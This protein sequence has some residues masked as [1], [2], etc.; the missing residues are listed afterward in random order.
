MRSN[1]MAAILHLSDLHFGKNLDDAGE[2]GKASIKGL[3]KSKRLEMQAHDPI[4]VTVMPSEIK[5]AARSLGVASDSFDFYVITGDVA[6]NGSSDERFDFAHKFL[7]D[8]LPLSNKYST[9]LG[10]PP[11]K[12]LCVPGNH[13][14]LSQETSE[15]YLRAFK[16]LPEPPPYVSYLQASNGQPFVF[17]GIDSNF[18]GEGNIGV[19]RISLP[20][21]G[22]LADEFSKIDLNADEENARVRV[23]VLHHH[24]ADLNQFRRSR[25]IR[26]VIFDH[27][28]VLENGDELLD[29]C[30][31]RIDLIM[32]GHEHFPIAFRDDRSGCVIVSGGTVSEW[33]SSSIQ[34]N[35][36]HSLLFR[37]RHL[38][39][40]QF[41]WIEHRFRKSDIGHWVFDLTR[42]MD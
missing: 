14:V 37:N 23:L 25:S 30:R 28:T 1:Q 20:T 33:Q 19:G 16:M 42:Q 24:P 18:Y 17:Y 36:F 39:V 38:E 10:L 26:S 2:P 6:T 31:G 29:L 15:R 40:N 11:E 3:I 32:H 41:D 21:I 5:L 34:T 7:T 9:G 35:T 12:L 4:I 27:F 22:W 13:D 8:K